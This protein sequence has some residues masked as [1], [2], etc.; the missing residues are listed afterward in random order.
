MVL[1]NICATYV[2][3]MQALSGE[4]SVAMLGTC[5]TRQSCMQC[6][7]HNLQHM[8]SLQLASTWTLHCD[9]AKKFIRF[10]GIKS[11]AG[12][13][14]SVRIEAVLE[15]LLVLVSAALQPVIWQRTPRCPTKGC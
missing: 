15:S 14:Q 13:A 2:H 6:M 3:R 10:G 8:S 11:V 7:L 4:T 5:L 1:E 12:T 9:R